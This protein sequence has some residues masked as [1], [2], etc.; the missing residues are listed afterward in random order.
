M[1][2]GNVAIAMDRGGTDADGAVIDAAADAGLSLR[3]IHGRCSWAFVHDEMSQCTA[4]EV[5]RT[6]SEGLGGFATRKFARG[7]CI[8]AEPPL[9]HWKVAKG[10]AITHEGV[11]ALVSAHGEA[12]QRA[13]WSLS[14]NAVHGTV[15]HAFGIWLTNAYPTDGSN[16]HSAERSSAVFTH[17]C[18]LNHS[19]CP[20]LHCSWNA[21]LGAQTV[22][23]LCDIECG[24]ELT[25]SYLPTLEQSRAVRRSALQAGFGFGCACATCSL[26]G[27]ALAA[28]ER[29]RARLEKLGEEVRAATDPSRAAGAMRAAMASGADFRTAAGQQ[30]LRDL[31]AELRG[32]GVA[33]IEERLALLAQEGAVHAARAWATL[34]AAAKLCT[35]LGDRDEAG[36]WTAKAAKC[37]WLALGR[38]S[39]DFTRYAEAL[40]GGVA[41]GTTS[42]AA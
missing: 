24:A 18:R 39:A 14:Q 40:R 38:E 35:T 28:S 22:Y 23:A 13:F 37:A 19:C 27:D 1:P 7:E 42:R 4:F 10:N 33:L 41:R 17:I 20:N 9:L 2:W 5:R 12:V 34:E 36:R 29:R 25:V 11:E 8:L 26:T 32:E 31:Q 21:A 6:P 16:V 3:A 30:K 15:K